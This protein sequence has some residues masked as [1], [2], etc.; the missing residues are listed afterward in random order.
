MRKSSETHSA[1]LEANTDEIRTTVVM[2]R[3]LAVDFRAKARGQDRS[4]W[5]RVPTAEFGDVLI[6]VGWGY[7]DGAYFPNLDVLALVPGDDGID[8]RMGEL[9][10]GHVCECVFELSESVSLAELRADIPDHFEWIKERTLSM[11]GESL[12]GAELLEEALDLW[13]SEMTV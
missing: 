12:V 7:D 6:R 1:E 8:W 11:M 5:H 3:G 2:P 4:L 10:D 9:T 13:A